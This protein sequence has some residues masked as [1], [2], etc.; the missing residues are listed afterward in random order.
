VLEPE[1]AMGASVAWSKLLMVQL[2]ILLAGYVS[3]PPVDP[4]PDS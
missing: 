2:D 3:E 1:A 4:K